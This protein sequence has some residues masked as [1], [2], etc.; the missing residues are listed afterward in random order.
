MEADDEA[1]SDVPSELEPAVGEA[2]DF[3]SF[4]A[5]RDVSSELDHKLGFVASR[6]PQWRPMLGETG[7]SAFLTAFAFATLEWCVQNRVWGMRF[8]DGARREIERTI[9]DD[10]SS[11]RPSDRRLLPLLARAAA[12]GLTLDELKDAFASDRGEI[13]RLLHAVAC[14]PRAVLDDGP[15][16]NAADF[17]SAAASDGGC[18]FDE[19]VMHVLAEKL[20]VHLSIIVLDDATA[21]DELLLVQLGKESSRLP[22]HSPCVSLLTYNNMYDVLYMGEGE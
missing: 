15:G 20:G 13:F 7:R 14:S 10:A 5:A 22:L 9:S 21:T 19:Y 12:G 4:Q 17:G 1:P 18:E 16:S 8:A 2:Q 11:S 3:C 6:Y